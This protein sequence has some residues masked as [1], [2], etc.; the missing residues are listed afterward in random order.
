M[1]YKAVDVGSKHFL[2]SPCQTQT[3]R[4]FAPG[5]IRFRCELLF[6]LLLNFAYHVSLL[7]NKDCNNCADRGKVYEGEKVAFGGLVLNM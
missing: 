4:I 2:C 7:Q 6:L 3:A 5:L 1:K